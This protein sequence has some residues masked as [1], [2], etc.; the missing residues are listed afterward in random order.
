MQKVILEKPD[1]K[2]P[3]NAPLSITSVVSGPNGVGSDY[4]FIYDIDLLS[5]VGGYNKLLIHFVEDKIRDHKEL[6]N[7]NALA[8]DAQ[9]KC[10][11][12]NGLKHFVEVFD[13]NFSVEE[14]KEH[15]KE[16]GSIKKLVEEIE[17]IG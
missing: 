6:T 17:E 9:H 7:L 14:A 5:N 13:T 3:V 12:F 15:F 1:L 16:P 4:D 2:R 8:N 10:I 11:S